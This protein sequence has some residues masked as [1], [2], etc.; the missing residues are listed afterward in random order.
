MASRAV[1]LVSSEWL[2][3]C[4]CL[5]S[6]AVSIVL[7]NFFFLDYQFNEHCGLF[8]L[9]CSH[10]VEQMQKVL[11]LFTAT[12]L[13]DGLVLLDP[14]SRTK[15]FLQENNSCLKMVCFLETDEQN[16][17]F[18]QMSVALPVPPPGAVIRVIHLFTDP[19]PPLLHP[20]DHL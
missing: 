20:P 8:F 16:L 9:R 3:P 6:V 5:E 11:S 4:F 19:P 12:R 2:T 10:P 1:D 15:P 18:F 17:A 14:I 13:V 7:Q